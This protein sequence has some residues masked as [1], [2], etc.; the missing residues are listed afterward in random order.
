MTPLALAQTGLS[1]LVVI[2]VQERLAAAMPHEQLD[3]LTR[4]CTIL[5]QAAQHLSVPTIVTE[6]YPKGLGP[7][8]RELS[9]WVPAVGAAKKRCFSC[10]ES[11]EF[12]ARFDE[13]RPQVILAGMEAHICVLQT[14]LQL[15]AQGKTVFVVEDATLS[16]SPVHHANAMQRLVQAGV[17]VSN[18]ESVVFEWLKIA[19]GEA[20]KAISR[21]V[22]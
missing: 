2:D 8:L 16:R 1:Q 19:E 21:L 3:R 5:L 15:K 4:N 11:D 6:Q 14:A 17:I 20:F 7:T 18:T 9:P 13:D 22:R 10:C 12:Q